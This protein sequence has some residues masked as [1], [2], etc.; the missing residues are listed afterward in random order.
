MNIAFCFNLKHT[1]PSKNYSAQ[2]EADFDPPETIDGIAKTLEA[3]GHNVIRIEADQK[4]YL[5]FLKNRE[6][7]KIVFNISEGLHGEAREAQIPSILEM[8]KIPYTHSGPMAQAISLDKRM[9]KVVLSYAGIHTPKRKN[10]QTRRKTCF[11]I[12]GA[13]RRAGCDS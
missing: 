9:T 8:L 11:F 13:K 6:I 3:G 10:D 7:I 12:F 2:K 5:E 1:Q 4:S